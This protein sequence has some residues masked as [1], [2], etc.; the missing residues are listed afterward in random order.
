MVDALQIC[1]C[2]GVAVEKCMQVACPIC[3]S[4][5][6]EDFN[7]RVNV[8]CKGC[9]SLERTRLL[10]VIMQRM[11]LLQRTS[12]VLHCAPEPGLFRKL[13]KV[14]EDYTAA[15]YNAAAYSKWRPD[16]KFIDLCNID[17]FFSGPYD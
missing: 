5:E 7:G 2:I 6:F 8:R 4:S 12:K 9:R 11:G 17:E 3:E 10:Y 13:S 1:R 14:Y 15:D 16:V